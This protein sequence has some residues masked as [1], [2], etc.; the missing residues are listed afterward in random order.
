M[1]HF[2]LCKDL[3]VLP[4]TEHFVRG[5][6]IEGTSEKDRIYL[7]KVVCPLHRPLRGAIMLNY[8]TR[9]GRRDIYLNPKAYN[10]SASLIGSL[11]S[12]HVDDLS[13]IRTPR[14]F[15]RHIN[16]SSADR[17]TAES[18][19]FV[20]RYDLALTLGRLGIMRE[21]RDLL[22]G[23]CVEI[24]TVFRPMIRK[25]KKKFDTPLEDEIE[26]VT[27]L[28]RNDPKSLIVLLDDWERENIEQLSLEPTRVPVASLA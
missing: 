11:I 4:P 3:L 18:A 21:C 22:E 15:L 6:L 1:P 7:W 10:E 28:V 9:I 19:G 14:D 26:R 5:F 8:S 27:H 23:L 13:S 16:W 12:D 25:S 20:L 2:A 24:D 17:W